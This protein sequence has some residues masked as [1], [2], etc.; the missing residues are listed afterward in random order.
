MLATRLLFSALIFVHPALAR[1]TPSDVEPVDVESAPPAKADKAPGSHFLVEGHAGFG[2]AGANGVALGGMLGAGGRVPST[3]LRLYLVG[4]LAQSTSEHQRTSE[5]T[6]EVVEYE[7]MDAS[8]G[9]RGYVPV[10]GRLRFFTD[11]LVGRTLITTSKDSELT[12][13]H[14][15]TNLFAVAAGLQLR[16]VDELSCGVRGRVGFADDSAGFSSPGTGQRWSLG[17]TLT[18]H[19]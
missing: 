11:A 3:P 7:A 16:V 15:W 17:A 5:G 10:Y 4:E 12:R 14:E 1:A 18:A 6:T 8:L 2:V 9:L 19:F 13:A